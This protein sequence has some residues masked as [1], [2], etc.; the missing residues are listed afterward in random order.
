MISYYLIINLLTFIIWGYDKFRATFQQWRVPEKT[1]TL[2]IILGGGL[3]ALLG[4]TVFRHKSRKLQYK[5]L[6]MAFIC[7]HITLFVYVLK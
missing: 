3:G 6:S 7:V 2:L 5:I 4:I 1:L